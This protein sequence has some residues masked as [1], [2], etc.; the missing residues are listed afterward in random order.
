MKYAELREDVDVTWV[1]QQSR[2][3]LR[4]QSGAAGGAEAMREVLDRLKKLENKQLEKP[5]RRKKKRGEDQCNTDR[6]V[7]DEQPRPE[8]IQYNQR[9]VK[10][11][12]G[13]PRKDQ[14]KP[15]PEVKMGE[16]RS[17]RLKTKS[18]AKCNNM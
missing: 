7:Q 13:R 14:A 17:E 12:R 11:K 8:I 4:E 1:F 9:P 5:R 18:V 16:R 10:R 15:R 2:T 3:H 6:P